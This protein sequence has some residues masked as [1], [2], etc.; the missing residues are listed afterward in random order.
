[1]MVVLL[2]MSLNIK[3]LVYISKLSN[4]SSSGAK[5]L[6]KILFGMLNGLLMLMLYSQ[7]GDE[8]GVLVYGIMLQV[9]LLII[10]NRVLCRDSIKTVFLLGN[11]V[12]QNYLS[13][14]LI[15]YITLR[16]F[17][18]HDYLRTRDSYIITIFL[19]LGL[20]LFL[21][22]NR[23]PNYELRIMFHTKSYARMLNIWF[24]VSNIFL[25]F[26]AFYILLENRIAYIHEEVNSIYFGSAFLYTVTCMLASYIIAVMQS[27]QIRV[28]TKQEADINGQFG[29]DLYGNYLLRYV[30][31]VTTGEIIFGRELFSALKGGYR[32]KLETFLR[33]CVHPDDATSF[34]EGLKSI[35]YYERRLEN[36]PRFKVQIRINP[37]KLLEMFILPDQATQKISV[38]K[39]KW[40][41]TS[42]DTIIEK[43]ADKNILL[44]V[45]MRD[46]N[47]EMEEKEELRNKA[48][49]HPLTGL[50]NRRGWEEAVNKNL[51][52]GFVGALVM[53][54]LDHF[55]DVND[56]L[57]H[58]EGD[59]VL[60]ETADILRETFRSSDIIGHIG[61][62]EFCVFMVNMID[63]GGIEKRLD[64]LL[65]RRRK[66]YIGKD[67]EE[68]KLSFS[69]G[70]SFVLEHGPLLESLM[71]YSDIALYRAKEEG[72]DCWRFANPIV[73][74]LD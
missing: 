14:F 15:T 50:L 9:I 58:Q 20:L 40:M 34:V 55:K 23:F 31:N 4:D 28:N 43:N 11:A 49:T 6:Y 46:I 1:M 18:V 35:D 63:K 62:D 60:R 47:D 61:G 13:L 41:W 70:V 57:G 27:L 73:Y 56:N 3:I 71:S 39:G 19:C 66:V 72:R 12:L 36:T 8:Y 44:Y 25:L 45:A 29:R 65:D 37:K 69:I 26:T 74:M 67:G 30:V 54:D 22:S 38:F 64:I 17:C 59:Y 16:L 24:P 2:V 42:F 53:I 7:L 33:Q 52:N 5:M 32:E 51:R 10:E 68:K 48:N 21:D